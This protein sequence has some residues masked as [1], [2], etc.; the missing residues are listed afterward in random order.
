MRANATRVSHKWEKKYKVKKH[1]QV[2]QEG[3]I[4]VCTTF[5]YNDDHV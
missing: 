4:I 1:R 3:I 2:I 5:Y